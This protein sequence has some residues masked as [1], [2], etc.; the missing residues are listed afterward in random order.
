MQMLLLLSALLSM[1]LA[2][3]Q[4][5]ALASHDA[6]SLLQAPL[7]L[8]SATPASRQQE[9]QQPLSHSS[10]WS[11]SNAGTLMQ[12]TQHL[13]L[14]MQARSSA[15]GQ[16]R[17]QQQQ[18]QTW[19]RLQ[20]TLLQLVQAAAVPRL[21]LRSWLLHA[22][23][24]MAGC[25]LLLL[26]CLAAGLAWVCRRCS[27]CSWQCSSSMRRRIG[28]G[29]SC[30][31][32]G[33]CL[34]RRLPLKSTLMAYIAAASYDVLC[35]QSNQLPKAYVAVT[36]C[37]DGMLMPD[38]C[39][40]A[41]DASKQLSVALLLFFHMI[42]CVFGLSMLCCRLT[43]LE[44][45]ASHILGVLGRLEEQLQQPAA[46]VQ[47]GSHALLGRAAAAAA[48]AAGSDLL[49]EP[50]V[51]SN[52]LSALDRIEAQ[53]QEIRRRWFGSSSDGLAM[54]EPT[55]V[56]QAAAAAVTDSDDAAASAMAVT[57]AADIHAALGDAAAIPPTALEVSAQQ[58]QRQQQQQQ[59]PEALSKDALKSIKAGRRRFLKHQAMVDGSLEV[60]DS[61]QRHP[62]FLESPEPGEAGRSDSK[63]ARRRA[64]QQ[65]QPTY[66]VE[67]VA[68]LLL[69]ELLFGQVDEL[70]GFCDALC[71]Q[72]FEEE[73][74]EA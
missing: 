62:A 43:K 69:D 16:D 18:Q 61:P 70:E 15:S 8:P 51:V 20:L 66:V 3:P 63:T 36:E 74:V 27:G 42:T 68:D 50:A 17:M 25:D 11:S 31:G 2:L 58:Q 9:Q 24:C 12:Q 26:L 39:V 57:K 44:E 59:E 29:A 72:L 7:L 10:I 53:E 37:T 46:D 14:T 30:L 34:L 33:I 45:T 52:V 54:P 47:A 21:G 71:S 5:A 60:M 65:L 40:H 73:F 41:F 23:G 6:P 56:F 28:Q 4:P 19:P 38:T 1:Q 13:Q 32:R 48:A 55:A 64:K 49:Q 67:A 22:R 35:K